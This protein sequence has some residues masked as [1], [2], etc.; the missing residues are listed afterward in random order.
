MSEDGIEDAFDVSF[1]T[2]SLL[3]IEK[4]FLGFK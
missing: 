2:H 3:C 1:I 4:S